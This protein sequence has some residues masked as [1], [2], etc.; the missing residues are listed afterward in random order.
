MR[1]L[2]LLL[3]LV[4]GCENVAP[5]VCTSDDDCLDGTRQGKCIFVYEVCAFSD[6]TCTPTKLR[7]DESAGGL[8]NVCVGDEGTRTP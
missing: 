8:A 5:F 6:S 4:T 1:R 2:A 7:F 3:V